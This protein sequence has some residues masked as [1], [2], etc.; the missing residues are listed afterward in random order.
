MLPRRLHALYLRYVAVHADRLRSVSLGPRLAR[1]GS[2]ERVY[3]DGPQ[4]VVEGWVD[5]DKLIFRWPG[6]TAE[7]VPA[8]P[9]GDVAAARGLKLETGF[10]ARVPAAAHPLIMQ[11]ELGED[12][13]SIAVPHP[14]NPPAKSAKLRLA[15]TFVRDL[16]RSLPHAVRFVSDPSDNNR[17]AFKRAMNL[18]VASVGQHITPDWLASETADVA[19]P[20]SEPVYIIV[21]VYNAPD[22]T[23]ACLT[24]LV[25]NTN[26]PWHAVVINDG[27]TDPELGLWL[28]AWAEKNAASVTLI[29]KPTNEGFVAAVNSGFEA[30][31]KAGHKGPVV[32]L[33]TDALVPPTWAERLLE[34]LSD[35]R[36]ASVT[37]MSNDAEILSVP[38]IVEVSDILIDDAEFLDTE[39]AALGQGPQ[40]VLPTGVGFCM[41][42]A[43]HWL[44]RVPRFDKAFGRGYGE[45]VDWCQKVRALGGRHVAQPR[46]FVP[47]IGGQS[48]GASEK[49]ERVQKANAE[50]ARRYGNYDAEVQTFIAEDPLATPRMALGIALAG[51]LSNPL[52]LF[53]SHGLGGGAETALQKEISDHK[54]A[55][56]LRVGGRTRW[57]LELYMDGMRKASVQT[58]DISDIHSLLAPVPRLEIVYSCGVSD[59][60]PITLPNVLLNLRRV[61]KGDRLT[62][63]LHDFF[64]IS[65]S[66]TLIGSSGFF[67][68]V[69]TSDTQDPVHRTARPDGTSVAL[70]DWQDAWG[71]FL[72]ETD[73]VVAFSKSSR[74]IFSSVFPHVP[75]TLR[76]HEMNTPIRRV[77]R[78]IRSSATGILGNLNA[79]KGAYVLKA[80]AEAH[81]RR[82]FVV[83][84][85]VDSTISMPRNVTIHGSYVPEDIPHLA[86][87]YGLIGWLMPAVW[88][89]TFS[90]VTHE[91]IAT[92]LPV[93]GF[94]LGAQAEALLRQPNGTVVALEPHDTCGERLFDA[95]LAAYAAKQAAE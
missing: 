16:V 23:K 24:N 37:P 7:V 49:L 60:D 89:E 5:A 58:M 6:G 70:S 53:L 57:Q 66:Y 91:A 73:E 74:A 30:V 64:P 76:P 36:V 45:E 85:H 65:P 55:L 82:R 80:M 25:K 79:Q 27:S 39:A 72:K 32:L 94:D 19:R 35:T 92:G 71:A 38:A 11:M 50:I 59:P 88:P 75:L 87:K 31:E 20:T 62:V 13:V 17:R 22:L 61:G 84:G 29:S 34:P 86:E 90:F 40:V 81:P 54:A 63:R 12:V 51:R 1:F 33:N 69:P 77:T 52:S 56:V 44:E 2:I 28:G 14:T 18:D 48:F 46:L 83:I 3:R 68:G 47:H 41:A 95:L 26:C 67:E 21:P 8:L 42:L 93:V 9:R 10:V 4:V 15:Y 43:G 78:S